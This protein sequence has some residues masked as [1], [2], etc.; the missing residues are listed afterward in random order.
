[1]ELWETLFQ[2]DRQRIGYRPEKRVGRFKI[3][4]AAEITDIPFTLEQVRCQPTV[5]DPPLR[6]IVALHV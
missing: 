5:A 3:R 4:Q 1:M 2:P 6:R